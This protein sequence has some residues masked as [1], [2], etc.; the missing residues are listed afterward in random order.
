M[1]A[2]IYLGEIQKWDDPRIASANAGASLP[3]ADISVV[4]RSDGCSATLVFTDYLSKVSPEWKEKVGSGTAVKWPVGVGAKG[5][6]G[7]TAIMKK[8]PNSVCYLDLRWASYNDAPLASLSNSAG[9]FVHPTLESITAAAASANVPDDLRV[10]ITDA[11]GPDSYPISSFTYLLVYQHQA[12]REKGQ[13]ISDFLWWAVHDGQKELH[14][15][16]Y[17]P[18]PESVIQMAEQKID[19]ISYN[20]E[21]LRRLR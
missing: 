7:V 18:L 5:D 12:D 16:L 11:P 17:A 1:L 19:S 20:D 14:K 13:L 4:C 2:A 21:V 15:L 10:S 9:Q 6:E 3:A 8:T